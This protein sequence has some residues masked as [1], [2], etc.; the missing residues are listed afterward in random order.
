M[1]RLA[2]ARLIAD[3]RP[4]WVKIVDVLH[5]LGFCQLQ[6]R[7]HLPQGLRHHLPS[8][9][10]RQPAISCAREL[11]AFR[12]HRQTRQCKAES[13]CSKDQQQSKKSRDFQESSAIAFLTICGA[14]SAACTLKADGDRFTSSIRTPEALVFWTSPILRTTR[15]LFSICC[16]HLPL[17]P[18]RA[19]ILVTR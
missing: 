8:S 19:L 15:W 1:P 17:E 16:P 2:N 11:N 13:A 6:T 5:A 7:L 18:I 10:T 9:N 12:L 3:L 14:Q 4:R